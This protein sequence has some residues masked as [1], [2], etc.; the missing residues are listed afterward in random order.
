[1]RSLQ[2]IVGQALQAHRVRECRVCVALSGGIDSVALLDVLRSL[3]PAHRLQLSAV[4]VNHGLSPRAAQWE[5]FC[6]RL[7]ARLRIPLLVERVQVD[8]ADELGLEAAARRARYAVFA[9]QRSDFVATAHHLDDQ[10]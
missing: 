3:S 2:Q 6:S 10:A 5:S 7:C 8:R 1:M 9:R 4:H